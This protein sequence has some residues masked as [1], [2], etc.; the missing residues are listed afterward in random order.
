[1]NEEA[2][3]SLVNIDPKAAALRLWQHTRGLLVPAV[4]TDESQQAGATP[5]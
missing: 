2:W 5:Q 1:M 3:W 4:A